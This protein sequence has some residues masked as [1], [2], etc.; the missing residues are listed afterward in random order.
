MSLRPRLTDLDQRVLRH[1]GPEH[2]GVPA[3][4]VAV[5]VGAPEIDIEPILH[6]LEHLGYIELRGCFWRRTTDGTDALRSRTEKTK[7]LGL[8]GAEH[9]VNAIHGDAA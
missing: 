3:S 1:V 7:Q 9:P 5:R 6:G 2:A 8:L 4:H